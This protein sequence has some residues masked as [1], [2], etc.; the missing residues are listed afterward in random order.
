MR[1]VD[2]SILE[3]GISEDVKPKRSEAKF[4]KALRRKKMHSTEG[5]KQSLAGDNLS[6]EEVV[7]VNES[8]SQVSKFNVSSPFPPRRG[9]VDI[10]PLSPL[11]S[12]T[13]LASSVNE[14][15]ET[16]RL[17]ESVQ[18]ALAL[19]ETPPTSV[20]EA[21]QILDWEEEDEDSDN[22]GESLD[23]EANATRI[24]YVESTN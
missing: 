1:D 3:L 12:R 17:Q 21:R 10:P 22:E 14:Q 18:F 13:Q 23:S 4:P 9:S 2:A 11:D 7:D 19:G 24:C 8:T 16:R 20:F 6:E 5:V 15:N